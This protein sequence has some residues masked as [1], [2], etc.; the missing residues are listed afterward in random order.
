MSEQ[1]VSP[2]GGR[3]AALR[4]RL[5]A[6]ELSALLVTHLPNVFYL[7][8]FSGSAGG[9]LVT[10]DAVRLIVDSRYATAARAAAGLVDS[11]VITVVDVD[12]SY[13]VTYRDLL[14]A[15]GA[16]RVGVEATHLTLAQY[17]WL[18]TALA[19]VGPELVSSRGLVEA[20]RL[21]KDADELRILTEAG[22][23][24]STVMDAQLTRLR[25]GATELEMAADIDHA[26]RL[27]GF[28]RPAFDTI[29][30]S[31][32]NTAL[33]H[34]SPGTRVIEKG[35]LVLIDFGGVA[36]GYCVDIT[37]VASLGPA[38]EEAVGWHDAVR[39]AHQAALDAVSV[40][41]T[42]GAVDTAARSSL[43]RRGL[44]NAFCHGT[45]HGLGIEVHEGPRVGRRRVPDGMVDPEDVPL[46]SGMVFTVEPGVY[47]PGQGG[48]RLEDDLVVT[49]EGYRL[50]TDVSL[51]LR[52]V[53]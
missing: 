35:D 53:G 24:I 16:A 14:R 41:T 31:G 8:G 13:E 3:L 2:V 15:S 32:P 18:R 51:D 27:A 25:P 38:S 7:T 29:V 43:E 39:A 17:E 1:T 42:T 11:G 22:A 48:V 26:I 46:E 20:G 52:E 6:A 28:E 23:R 19:E 44:G 34:A 4:Q 12:S 37:R 50:L 33:P 49:P 21:V 5:D 10:P 30:A 40:G 36:R 47:L 9:A 45:G